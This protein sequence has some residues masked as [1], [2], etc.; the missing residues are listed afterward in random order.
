VQDRWYGP[1]QPWPAH[2]K[3]WWDEPLAQARSAGWH[4]RV[5]SGHAWGKVVCSRI[6][7]GPCV[8]VIFSTGRGGENHA[9]DLGRL[10][11]RCRHPRASQHSALALRLEEARRLLDGAEQ[12]IQAAE[13]W[14]A[15]DADAD[16]VEDLLGMAQDSMNVA[17][18]LLPTDADDLLDRAIELDRTAQAR[19]T[20]AWARATV[21]GYPPAE[22]VTAGRL[23][24]EAER[25]IASAADT[26]EEALGMAGV[27]SLRTRIQE[28]RDRLDAVRSQLPEQAAE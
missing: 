7:D 26:V 22:Q 27:E 3:P 11:Q 15:A 2:P 20:E 10:V 1:D 6:I 5:F 25:R 17:E 21:A 9:K 18:S 4:L 19:R 12:L 23:A 14:L 28:L 24:D 13:G 16:A 8:K